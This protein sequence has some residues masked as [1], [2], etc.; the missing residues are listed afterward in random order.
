MNNLSDFENF[1]ELNFFWGGG[2]SGW[3]GGRGGGGR[4]TEVC[5]PGAKN[6]RYASADSRADSSKTKLFLERH[7][8]RLSMISVKASQLAKSII[9]GEIM[10][11]AG[12]IFKIDINNIR[13]LY[14]M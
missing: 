7:R 4:K 8:N 9:L 11:I 6:H 13:V 10:T 5:A 12:N 1:G 14:C 3:G 2:G